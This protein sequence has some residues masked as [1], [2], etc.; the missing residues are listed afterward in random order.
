MLFRSAGR[1]AQ[2]EGGQRA[3][4]NIGLPFSEPMISIGTGKGTADALRAIG[5]KTGLAKASKAV[6]ESYPA[7]RLKAL[8]D[9][10]KQGLTHP[11]AQLHATNSTEEMRA[12]QAITRGDT[13]RA[14]RSDDFKGIAQDDLRRAFENAEKSAVEGGYV[15]HP[16]TS[17]ASLDPHV[18]LHINPQGDIL[19]HFPNAAD[20]GMLDDALKASQP[21]TAPFL[22]LDASG[23][24]VLGKGMLNQKAIQAQAKKAYKADY[25]AK[26][27]EISEIGRAHV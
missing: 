2:I 21:I 20:N 9:Y 23:N 19:K 16:A 15:P 26:K 4:L 18:M 13:N 22:H 6:S 10:R 1:V 14:I 24:P 11:T 7:T 25:I 5:R 27:A 17:D 8:F 3:L 12:L